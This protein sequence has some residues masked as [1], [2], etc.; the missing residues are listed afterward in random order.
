MIQRS[1]ICLIAKEKAHLWA[2]RALD[3]EG[4]SRADEVD[5]RR[6]EAK[7]KGAFNNDARE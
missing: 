1:V 5:D 3:E 4:V 2:E 6:N 7:F